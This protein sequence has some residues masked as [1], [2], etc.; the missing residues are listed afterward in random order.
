MCFDSMVDEDDDAEE[1]EE[2]LAEVRAVNSPDISRLTSCVLSLF[3]SETSR[4][5]SGRWA[6]TV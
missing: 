1:S 6:G 3:A 5:W 4:L 2:K